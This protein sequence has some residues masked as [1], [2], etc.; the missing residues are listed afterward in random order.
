[1]HRSR[2]ALLGLLATATPLHAQGTFTTGLRWSHSPEAGEAWIPQEVTFAAGGSFVWGAI[3]GAEPHLALLDGV[4]EGAV[5]SREEDA[6]IAAVP[7]PARVAAGSRADAVFSVAQHSTTGPF[8]RIS[9]VSRH[10]PLA[11]ARGLGFAPVWTHDLGIVGNGPAR[12]ACDAVGL[13]VLAAVHD[14]SSGTVRVDWLSGD[15]GQ[16]LARVDLPALGLSA[17]AVD[18]EG[19]RAAVLAGLDL[20]VL[21]G[22]GAVLEHRTLSASSP[23]LAISADGAR[24]AYG[25][26]GGIVGL[27]EAGSGYET[28]FERDVHP[29]WLPGDLALSDDGATL[30]AGWWNSTKGERARLEILDGHT[31]ALVQ[32]HVQ[33]GIAG[34]PQNLPAAVDVSD[35]GSRAAF[36]LWGGG[37]AAEPEVVVYQR[38]IDEPILEVDLDGSAFGLD[39]DA[40]GRRVAV[41][42]KEGHAGTLGARGRIELFDTGEADVEL[43]ETPEIG[44]ELALA[45]RHAG[46][47]TVL[48]L[49]GE[50]APEPVEI[51][52]VAGE[53]YLDRSTLTVFGRVADAAGRAD[54]A[55]P[56]PNDPTWIGRTLS[57]QAA[58]RT[59]SGLVLSADSPDALVLAP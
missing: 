31:G 8:D 40:A 42:W 48:F 14:G 3:D 22:D 56:V 57:S 26:P 20:Y 12:I 32:R 58:F 47:S 35:D 6:S 4:A 53:L 30:A 2:F 15:T 44:G 25:R 50:R 34:G 7:T 11:A 39:L 59:G 28:A 24:V 17:V 21:D 13:R 36:G 54:L 19:E 10:D 37:A 5:A 38:G 43:A 49:L 51:R 55:L 52:G 1:M 16:V 45:A 33:F 23:A 27:R 18:G 9:L 41:A 46:A 29:V